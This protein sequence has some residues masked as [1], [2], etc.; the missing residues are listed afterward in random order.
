[1]QEHSTRCRT[2]S[3]A[4]AA[5]GG[6]G[7]SGGAEGCLPADEMSAAQLQQAECC[8]RGIRM[9]QQLKVCQHAQDP[10]EVVGDHAPVNNL[11]CCCC[12]C[13]C[14]C[15]RRCLAPGPSRVVPQ[16]ASDSTLRS[17]ME[18]T[19]VSL[20]LGGGACAD[21]MACIT[22]EGQSEGEADS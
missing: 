3:S 16:A 11:Q 21:Y 1:M 14:C 10:L 13:C 2:R 20:C 15:C 19:Q 7:G 18:Q 9:Q 12:C 8:R 17:N 4:A 22:K 5:A 6:G